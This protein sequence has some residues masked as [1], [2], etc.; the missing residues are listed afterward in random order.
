MG[1]AHWPIYWKFYR[2]HCMQVIVELYSW[3]Y[4]PILAHHTMYPDRKFCPTPPVKVHT[5][6]ISKLRKKLNLTLSGGSPSS[7]IKRW[8]E[9]L[10]Q[11]FQREKK[12]TNF[13]IILG[14]TFS[15]YYIIH[16]V[17]L[18]SSLLYSL[19]SSP[20]Y[21]THFKKTSL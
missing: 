1:V 20:H 16:T 13:G 11:I 5:A 17:K 18:S 9:K 12:T 8:I 10:L 3:N 19:I 2:Y 14:H 6:W 15:F 21:H 4:S 7:C